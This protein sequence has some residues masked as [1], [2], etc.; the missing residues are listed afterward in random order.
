MLRLGFSGGG[1]HL[2]GSIEQGSVGTVKTART[3]SPEAA[4]LAAG[5]ARLDESRRLADQLAKSTPKPKPPTANPD[6]ALLVT[7]DIALFWRAIEHAPADSLSDYLQRG[8]LD[9]ASVGVRDFI[10]GR[11]MSAEDLASYVR[12]HR[13]ASISAA[14]RK[15][16]HHR[17]DPAI[18]AAFAN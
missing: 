16:R 13:A 14:R 18:R 9:Q 1:R 17:A 8:Y 12:S 2:D 15:C 6:S 5:G 3:G 4:A 10:P 7:S 11:I